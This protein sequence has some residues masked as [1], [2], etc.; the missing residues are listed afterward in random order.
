MGS[1]N[2]SSRNQKAVDKKLQELYFRRSVIETLI[3][4]LE[5]YAEHQAETADGRLKQA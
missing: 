4:S 1:E 3:R 5:S 2:L